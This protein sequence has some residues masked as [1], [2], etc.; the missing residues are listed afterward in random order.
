MCWL[1]NCISDKIQLLSDGDD[2]EEEVLADMVDEMISGE[3]QKQPH[4]NKL[5]STNQLIPCP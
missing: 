5:V 1:V 3:L 4:Q 2:A